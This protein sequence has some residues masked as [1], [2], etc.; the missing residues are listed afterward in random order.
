MS[1]GVFKILIV[2][3]VS[4]V[5]AGCKLDVVVG[6]G[7]MVQS[8]S[9]TRDCATASNCT[10]EVTDTS[11]TETFTAVALPGYK[12]ERWQKG[13]EYL[14]FKTTDPTCKLSN[15]AYKDVPE[16][17]AMIASDAVYKIAPVFTAT[18]ATTTTTAAPATTDGASTP[19]SAVNPAT[20]A[21]AAIPATTAS[22]NSRLVVKDAKGRLL[23]DVMDLKNG[24]DAAV[25]QVF[26][27]KAK[28]EHG[29]M[30]DVNSMYMTDSYGYTVYWQNA[31]CAGK[32]VYAP[33]PLTLQPLF[34]NRYLVARK[35]KNRTEV[36][37]LLHLASPKEAKLLTDT[38][39]LEDGVCKPITTKFPL[40]KASILD[41]DYSSRYTPP[42]GVYAQ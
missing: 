9:K 1:P 26:I 28:K 32:V 35:E 20:A 36:L 31:A 40:V 2:L 30:V 22:A 25:R 8:T 23:G 11:F 18:T 33:S 16:M 27:N 29:Y 6:E 24:T 37:L 7:G 10:F 34:S 39:A 3:V 19:A 21:T 13:P 4:I 15:T 41:A 17:K 5:L 42:F 14:C 12:F 38:Y